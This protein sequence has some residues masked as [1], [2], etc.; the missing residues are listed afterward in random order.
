MFIFLLWV[1]F[2][3]VF[4]WVHYFF[5]A[6]GARRAA[7]FLCCR[8]LYFSACAP[9]AGGRRHPMGPGAWAGQPG[10]VFFFFCCRCATRFVFCCGC[11]ASSL[12]HL[13]PAAPEH[14]LQKEIQGPGR[15]FVFFAAGAITHSLTRCP[16][17]RAPTA[18]EHP[19]QKTKTRVP[20]SPI[21]LGLSHGMGSQIKL[22]GLLD[23]YRAFVSRDLCIPF[24]KHVL[25]GPG[26]PDNRLCCQGQRKPALESNEFSILGVLNTTHPDGSYCLPS[27]P[28]RSESP[29]RHI[30]ARNSSLISRWN[31]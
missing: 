31:P 24:Q 7:R 20:C 5:V 30:L 3:C 10:G 12:T 1:L 18:N 27:M 9:G 22:R 4:F 26:E 19:Q 11:A 23:I 13:P 25:E 6:A 17:P 16:P 29:V 2:C 14:P 8:V 15:V 28:G 21:G